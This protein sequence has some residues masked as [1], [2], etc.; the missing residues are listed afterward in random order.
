MKKLLK[1]LVISF[2]VLVVGIVLVLGY[3]GF[4]PGVST[5]F[6]SNKPRDLG[7]KHTA[8]DLAQAQEKLGGQTI[9][10]P[11]DDPFQQMKA[12]SGSPVN[13][14]LTQ[15][16][17]SAHVEKIHPVSD[18]QIKFSGST[19]EMS[20]RVDKS[21]IPAFIRTWGIAD[22]SDEEIL[23]IVNKYFPGDINFY[24]AGSGGAK[25]NDLTLDL[26]KVELGRIP[27]PVDQAEKVLEAY[28]E[29]LFKQFPGFWVE[30]STIQDGKLTF[31]GSVVKELPQY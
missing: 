14:T 31:K 23:G 28:S 13:A 24:L 17:Y 6:G 5:L 8:Q 9:V 18:I 27:I 2:L 30:D 21:R 29:T 3:F 12:S 15:E 26:T 11:K 20:G 4:M 10:V 22:V 1:F 25:N 16:E 19:F 7:V